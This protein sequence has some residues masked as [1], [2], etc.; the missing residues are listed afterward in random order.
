MTS[1]STA[2][3]LSANTHINDPATLQDMTKDLAEVDIY[4]FAAGNAMSILGWYNIA[5]N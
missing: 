4:G 1:I 3:V 5:F 2:K